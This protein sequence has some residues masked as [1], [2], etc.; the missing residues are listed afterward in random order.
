MNKSLRDK[1]LFDKIS[2]QYLKKDIYKASRVAR[3]T[4]LKQTFSLT[5]CSDEF[6]ILEVGCGAG[7]AARYLQ[8]SYKTYTGIDY[9][10]N[11]IK[12]AREIHCLP[13]VTFSA[14]DFYDFNPEK[15]YDIVFCIGVLHHMEDMA[16]ALQ[17][18]NSLVKP[19]GS[20]VVNEP[21]A[22]NIFFHILRKVRAK[23]NSDSYSDEQEELIPTLLINLFEKA[24]LKNI[25]AMPQGFFSTP[26]AEVILRPNFLFNPLSML[27]CKID[28][29]LE[30]YFK[31]VLKLGAWNL[32]VVG[33]K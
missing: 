23:T 33:R 30:K 13:N 22:A 21:Q 12:L 6:D 2:D 4:R 8:G 16:Y 25:E 11:L 28:K 27:A 31:G 7:Y 15:K 14:V 19:G 17:I 9:S 10:E 1:E 24:G 32:I 26:F 3:M 20:L 5:A 29:F 18:M